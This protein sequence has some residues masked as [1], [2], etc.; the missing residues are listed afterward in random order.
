[1]GGLEVH[2]PFSC[3]QHFDFR[4]GS[5][6]L[7]SIRYYADKFYIDCKLERLRASIVIA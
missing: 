7:H 3:T 1:M 6:F 4:E 5:N 2:H